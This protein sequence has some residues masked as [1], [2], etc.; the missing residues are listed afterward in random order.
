MTNYDDDDGLL[1]WLGFSADFY[2][3]SGALQWS[4]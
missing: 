2:A 4:T 1:G 3:T